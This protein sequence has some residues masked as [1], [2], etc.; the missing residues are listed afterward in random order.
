MTSLFSQNTQPIFLIHGF[1]GWGRDEMNGYYY[2]GGEQDFQE[3]LKAFGYEVYTLSVGPVSSNWDRAIEAYTQIKG[4]CI[5]YGRSHSEK[6]EI[7]QYPEGKCYE[8][9]YPQWDET[10]PVHIIGHSQGGLTARMLEYLLISQFDDE[11][12]SLLSKSH[13]GWIKSITTASTPHDGTTLT[14]II[15]NIFPFAQSIAAWVGSFDSNILKSFYSFDLDQWGLK[16]Q[17][18]ESYDEFWSRIKSSKI[19]NSK[20]FSSW[21]LSIEGAKQFNSIYSTNQ[22]TYY[23]S[24]A[25]Y[26]TRQQEYAERHLPDKNMRWLL[27]PAGLLIG[28]TKKENHFWYKNDGIVNT[29]S[30]YAPTTGKNGPEPATFFNGIPEKGIWQNIETYHMDHHKIIGA[31][32]NKEE[33]NEIFSIYLNHCKLLYGLK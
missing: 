20:N 12:S 32:V 33:A 9:L 5:N 4:G 3:K 27:W 14:P 24:F 30:M 29:I 22:L 21:D 15:M 13:S 11:S 16:K 8:G 26:A 28:Q 18:K 6:F 1:F 25:T 31:N 10:N 23:F 19:K 17:E 2:W 7:I